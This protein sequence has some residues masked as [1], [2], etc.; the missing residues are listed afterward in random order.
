MHLGW[1]CL[2]VQYQTA[3]PFTGEAFVV[4]GDWWRLGQRGDPRHRGVGGNQL[5]LSCTSAGNCGSGG[6]SNA[7]ITTGGKAIVASESNGTWGSARQAPGTAALN[8][9]GDALISAVSCTSAGPLQR[10]RLL[11]GRRRTP[12]GAHCQRG[13]WCLGHQEVPGTAA[14]N[15]GGTA[16]D[17]LQ[18]RRLLHR[19]LRTRASVRCRRIRMEPGAVQRRFPVPNVYRPLRRDQ[20]PSAPLQCRRVTAEQRLTGIRDRRDLARQPVGG[21]CGGEKEPRPQ[22]ADAQ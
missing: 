2:A 4:T 8:A 5:S 15:A 11:H 12:A 3:N 10:R 14:L 1:Q 16:A 20:R 22:P 17:Q 21:R 7:Q 9:G 18:R 19:R 13:E 6:E